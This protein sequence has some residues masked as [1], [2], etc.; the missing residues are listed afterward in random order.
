[1]GVWEYGRYGGMRMRVREYETLSGRRFRSVG[2][3][4]WHRLSCI[5]NVGA[6]SLAEI[7]RRS[8]TTRWMMLKKRSTLPSHGVQRSR[9]C[10]S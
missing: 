5:A 7:V 1:M 9:N 8:P 4:E 3:W 10:L 6:T 2:S